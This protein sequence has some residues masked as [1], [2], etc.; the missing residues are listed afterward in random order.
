ML[1]QRSHP[2]F[3]ADR[4][5]SRLSSIAD[6]DCLHGAQLVSTCVQEIDFSANI[7][8]VSLA[9]IEHKFDKSSTE[10]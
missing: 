5:R 9:S 1:A 3:R 8:K 7:A 4:A 6:R 2:S 10:W